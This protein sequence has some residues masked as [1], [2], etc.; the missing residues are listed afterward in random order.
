AVQNKPERSAPDI[1]R[2]RETSRSVASRA[3]LKRYASVQ[4][5]ALALSLATMFYGAA[6]QL[7]VLN[8]ES[9]PSTRA[10]THIETRLRAILDEALAAAAD[11]T[12]SDSI[13][14]AARNIWRRCGPELD[15]AMSA[16]CHAPALGR[17]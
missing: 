10:V 17:L 11:P 3:G 2:L 8:S 9:S 6:V 13:V 15:T 4:P 16:L 5:T 14:E 7:A 1:L 12:L